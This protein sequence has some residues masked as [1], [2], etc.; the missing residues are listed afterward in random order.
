MA[1][2][3]LVVVGILLVLVG[4]FLASG[5]LPLIAIGVLALIAGGILSV[6]GRRTGPG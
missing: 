3:A 4:I 2:A 5:N 1:I 6:W